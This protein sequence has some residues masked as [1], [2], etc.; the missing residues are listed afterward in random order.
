MAHPVTAEQLP[1]IAMPGKS[2]ELVRGFLV[3]RK[4]N[5]TRHG[6]VAARVTHLVADHVIRHGLGVV[7]Q[8]AGFKIESDPDTVRAPDVAFVARSRD[9][10]IPATGFAPFAPDFVAE[11]VSPTSRPGDVLSKVGQ[12]LDAGTKLVW[13]IDPTRQKA[14]VYRENGDVTFVRPDGVLR[15]EP[16]L[17]DLTCWLADV[18]R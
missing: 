7:V 16:V 17:S 11:V 5:S 14:I 12:W 2:V 1:G 9:A 3:V 6:L 18:L 4:P 10:E 13:V 15:G 8:H